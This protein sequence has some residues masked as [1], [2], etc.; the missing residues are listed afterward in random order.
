MR[1]A[2]TKAI[3]L[4]ADDPRPMGSVKIKGSDV[5][6]RIRKGD[7]RVMYAVY[8]DVVVVEIITIGH[9]KDIYK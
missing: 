3:L 5:I 8:D 4:L 6:Y 7:Y 1:K 9:R 2:I